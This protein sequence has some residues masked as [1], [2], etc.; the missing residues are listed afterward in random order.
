MNSPID[1]AVTDIKIVNG[2][3]TNNS[4]GEKEEVKEVIVY[5]KGGELDIDKVETLLKTRD[6]Q[7]GVSFPSKP[8]EV[9]ENPNKKQAY[10]FKG[11]EFMELEDIRTHPVLYSAK[12]VR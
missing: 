11:Y 9:V 10:I 4:V 5:E 8:I 7:G 12:I 1:K 6:R 3:I 2:V